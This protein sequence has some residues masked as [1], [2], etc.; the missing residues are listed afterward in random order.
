M[1]TNSLERTGWG[2]SAAAM[3]AAALGLGACANQ[4]GAT[5]SATEA[6]TVMATTPAVVLTSRNVRIEGGETGAYGPA[7]GAA[8]GGTGGFYTGGGSGTD[9]AIFAGLGA[10]IG[11]GLGY[12]AEEFA[13]S[14][15][16]I[17]YVLRDAA[18]GRTI[19]VVQN[20]AAGESP[21]PSGTRVLLQR[22]DRYVR[23]LPAP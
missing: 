13:D 14:R 20:A 7:L 11:A 10:L 8:L 9:S 18:T 16:G 19:T 5:Y 2:V 1:S 12:A 3:L 23:V 22:A 15:D 4:T 6:G 17:E 21:L